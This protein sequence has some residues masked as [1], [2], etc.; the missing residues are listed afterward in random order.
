MLIRRSAE[1][2]KLLTTVAVGTLLVLG[3]SQ[4]LSLH[5]AV[6]AGAD[7][8]PSSL[9]AWGYNGSGQLGNGSFLNSSDI[10]VLV[11]FPSGVTP[12]AVAGNYSDG[13]AIGSNGSL[14]AWGSNEALGNGRRPD[15]SRRPVV[16]PLPVGV[17]PTAIAAGNGSGADG[18]AI[19][20]DGNLYAWGD[21]THGQ[22]GNGSSGGNSDVPVKVLLPLGVTPTS[23]ASA[24]DSTYAIGSDGN[25]YAWGY[26]QF[27]ALGIG[28][29]ADPITGT[30]IPTKV[31][32]P[33]GVSANA[34]AANGQGGYD[35]SAYAIGSDGNLYAWGD[36]VYGELGIGAVGSGPE[37]CQNIQADPSRD[38]PVPVSLPAGT[39]PASI[40]A[41]VFDG[42]VLSTDG[43]LYG[44]GINS[45]GEL[46]SGSPT[47]CVP[48]PLPISLP[49][50]V[51]PTSIEAG[52]DNG[53]AI[54][55]DGNLYAWGANVDGRLG[56]GLA[57]GPDICGQSSC[58]TTPVPVTLPSGPINAVSG[59]FDTAYAIV[60][61]NQLRITTTSLPPGKV[62]VPYSVTLTAT[63]G[64]P[65]YRW[66]KFGGG[67]L[68][69]GLSFSSVGVLSGTPTEAGIWSV[70]FHVR[71]TKI[72]Y[73]TPFNKV[74]ATLTITIT[75]T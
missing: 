25:V 21:N 11:S 67:R 44:W 70:T 54:G 57:S 29:T 13:Y 1:L 45:G 28:S 52:Q 36:N 16:V 3:G 56:D 9:F 10:P 33:S 38:T 48:A 58:S 63:G 71:D 65:P 8:S 27:G 60:S 4:Y 59:G 35:A 55:S 62:G 53:Y 5:P 61:T 23:V 42:Y 20:S 47:D 73:R 24:G 22:L 12:T 2:V 51:T 15:G 64:N 31:L 18:Y 37:N 19:G 72:A 43:T 34:I 75:V 49:S 17:T 74:Y 41:G 6:A 46:A 32:L 68:P 30:D 39:T 7:G 66:G 50:P 14:Y 40:A 69:P 26:N